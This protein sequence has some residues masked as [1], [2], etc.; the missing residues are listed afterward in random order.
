MSPGWA[1]LVFFL[2]VVFFLAGF[3]FAWFAQARKLS[4]YKVTPEVEGLKQADI[5]R[6]ETAPRVI[7]TLHDD[8][9]CGAKPNQWC[10]LGCAALD[11]WDYR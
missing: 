10:A 2:C 7:R 1:T 11:P 8:C 4:Q 9:I 6:G 3:G 5:P